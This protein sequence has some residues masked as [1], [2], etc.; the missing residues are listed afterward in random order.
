MSCFWNTRTSCKNK[1]EIINLKS[2]QEL[3]RISI[4]TVRFFSSSHLQCFDRKAG[5]SSW[6]GIP[7]G[8]VHKTSHILCCTVLCVCVVVEGMVRLSW[9][10]IFIDD[11]SPPAFQL[12]SSRCMKTLNHFPSKK[13]CNFVI[14]L[15]FVVE[16][17][18]TRKRSCGKVMFLHLFVSHSVHKGGVSQH[19]MGAYT[20]RQTAPRHT[21]PSLGHIHTPGRHPSWTHTPRQTLP[22]G[23]T[24]RPGRHL[25][26]RRPPWSGRYAS[27]WNAF[28]LI[29]R[30]PDCP[31][32]NINSETDC[33]FFNI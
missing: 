25:P 22:P 18:T 6:S 24:P 32:A 15:V 2:S 3:K 4:C 17:I 12:S 8:W 29:Y 21:H 27:Y 16:I 23:H 30:F 11:F 19:A 7:C 26:P 5:T 9:K 1:F 20:P 31:E 13:H 14:E 10:I 28:L 33:T